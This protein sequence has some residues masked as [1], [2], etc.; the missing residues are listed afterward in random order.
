MRATWFQVRLRRLDRR[1]RRRALAHML[2]GP[3]RVRAC[4]REK[5]K[6]KVKANYA[7]SRKRKK[8]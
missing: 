7:I 8:G 1:V 5:E 2:V 6:D 4:P 3:I